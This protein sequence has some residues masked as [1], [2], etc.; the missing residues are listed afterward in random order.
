MSYRVRQDVRSLPT[1]VRIN[2]TPRNTE[3]ISQ[4]FTRPTLAEMTA[5]DSY[6]NLELRDTLSVVRANNEWVTNERKKTRIVEELVTL[7]Q[8]ISRKPELTYNETQRKEKNLFHISSPD[9]TISLTEDG[10]REL[11]EYVSTTVEKLLKCS[12]QD[13]NDV[14]AI[15]AQQERRVKDRLHAQLARYP[16]TND[17]KQKQENQLLHA[18]DLFVLFYLE[19]CIQKSTPGPEVHSTLSVDDLR[20]YSDPVAHEENTLSGGLKNNDRRPTAM[21]HL[22]K[23]VAKKTWWIPL[24]GAAV[25]GVSTVDS[26]L[27][28]SSGEYPDIVANLS[29]FA[30]GD[31]QGMKDMIE[32]YLNGLDTYFGPEDQHRTR[33]FVFTWID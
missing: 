24:A 9:G 5:Y 6:G 31:R 20:S 27:H 12:V 7:I 8:K 3:S 25:G 10:R 18:S 32:Q 4:E 28:I 33:S 1:D 11:S 30:Q 14:L 23:Q 19:E 29:Q 2:M 21:K 15:A 13:R 17:E 22:L 16:H 26:S